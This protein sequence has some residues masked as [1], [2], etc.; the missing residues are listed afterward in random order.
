MHLQHTPNILKHFC[1][2]DSTQCKTV[3]RKEPSVSSC[4]KESGRGIDCRGTQTFFRSWKCFISWL[5]WW[6]HD[7]FSLQ[8]LIKWHTV[9]LLYL[10]YISTN[11][12]EQGRK[13]SLVLSLGSFTCIIFYSDKVYWA[14]VETLLQWSS[15]C[16]KNRLLSFKLS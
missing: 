12:G 4:Q 15:P 13:K 2:R 3:L 9:K 1:V 7:Y 5:W 11:L 10:C 6:W 14:I 16:N 8:K